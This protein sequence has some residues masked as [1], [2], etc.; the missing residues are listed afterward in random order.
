M[1]N[2]QNLKKKFSKLYHLLER[3]TV[4]KHRSVGIKIIKN[5]I[6]DKY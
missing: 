5:I 1:I 2:S 4:K 6:S 3:S